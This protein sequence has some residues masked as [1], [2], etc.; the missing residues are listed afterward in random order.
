MGEEQQLN[1]KN[2]KK[3]KREGASN[4]FDLIKQGSPIRSDGLDVKKE[5]SQFSK[6]TGVD[7][8]RLMNDVQYRAKVLV[9][10]N[11]NTDTDQDEVALQK[12]YEPLQRN[13]IGRE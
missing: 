12:I 1:G 9:N 7:F 10:G 11:S 2:E 13:L 8:L 6:E 5:L 3:Q 4:M